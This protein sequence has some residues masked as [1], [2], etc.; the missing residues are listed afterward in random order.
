LVYFV[1]F[2]NVHSS[3]FNLFIDYNKPEKMNVEDSKLK[4]DDMDVK[5]YVYKDYEG[6]EDGINLSD[7]TIDR[8]AHIFT[9]AFIKVMNKAPKETANEQIERHKEEDAFYAELMDKHERETTM[10]RVE[11]HEREVEVF[12]EGATHYSM[13]RPR[14]YTHPPRLFLG[15]DEELE[16]FKNENL[17]RQ[18]GS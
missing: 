14:I 8:K 2:E 7:D 9:R 5:E 12:H 3:L 4:A 6:S 11:R 13:I 16:K 17:K 15:T 1:L 10:E 18:C